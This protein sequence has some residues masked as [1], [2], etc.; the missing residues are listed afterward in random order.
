[1]KDIYEL[2]NDIDIDFDHIEKVELSEIERQRGKKKLMNSIKKKKINTKKICVA[3]AAI[4]V[5]GVTSI[6]I[7]N[8]T[9][10]KNIPFIG[11]LVQ[12]QLI[13]TNV[14]YENYMNILGQ[15]KSN[16]GIDVTFENAI[17]DN[18]ILF[19]SFVVKNNNEPISEKFLEAMLVGSNIKINN[20]NINASGSSSH[21]IIDENTVRILDQ[22]Q[23]KYDELPKNFDVDIDVSNVF[24]KI[25]DWGVKFSMDTKE[26]KKNTYVENMDKNFEVN[27]IG[28]NV[29]EITISPLTTNIKYYVKN[30][31]E[32]IHMD[33][34]VLDQD[35]NE[36]KGST[37]RSTTE[38]CEDFVKGRI[39]WSMNYISNENIKELTL[40][41]IY[42]NGNSYDNKAVND[43]K[44]VIGMNNVH[45]QDFKPLGFKLTESLSI[46]VNSCTVDGDNLIVKYDYKYN[47]KK[48]VK[49]SN[50]DDIFIKSNN[51]LLDP[52]EDYETGEKYKD[53]NTNVRVYK[54]G[55]AKNIEIGSYNETSKVLF[56]KEAFKAHLKK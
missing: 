18:N 35:G 15:T 25:G 23:L 40:I 13:S 38:E 5:I 41:P 11:N 29:N 7:S 36:V 12:N 1:M 8:P 24:G 27:G 42:Y 50:Y 14:E 32:K 54:I 55:D 21:E 4:A 17:V 16:E 48:I 44:Q 26:V 20:E 31:D 22:I 53:R 45:L 10:A 51:T 28:V 33:F 6:T 46:D 39:D 9:F 56:E 52:I 34:L 30:E 2:L 49:P 47:G 37:G 3:A 19:L 43:N